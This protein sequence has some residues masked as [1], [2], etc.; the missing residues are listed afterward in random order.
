M[1]TQQQLNGLKKGDILRYNNNG[2]FTDWY[3]DY[4]RID[5]PFT[6]QKRVI[7]NNGRLPIEGEDP[8]VSKSLYSPI[9]SINSE[10]SDLIN[11]HQQ[12][13]NVGVRVSIETPDGRGSHRLSILVTDFT[14]WEL[15]DDGTQPVVDPSVANAKLRSAA[16]PDTLVETQNVE[17]PQPTLP[18]LIALSPLAD[19]EN[20]PYSNPVI[21]F[22]FDKEVKLGNG[23]ITILG[24]DKPIY[25]SVT[26][27][28]V[29]AS[30]NTVTVTP[31]SDFKPSV[32]YR[33]AIAANA[34]KD[35]A[36]NA[37]IDVLSGNT[38][39]FT[40]ESSPDVSI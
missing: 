3:V 35:V 36:T 8:N 4:P 33:I 31:R 22:T 9:V 32:K 30:G 18:M 11:Q 5:I 12:V 7:V 6:K 1:L 39:S 40:T 29:E 24:E 20:V 17:T 15:K 27:S 14:N 34:I 10:Q 21:E 13:S 25:C 19:A 23:N 38:Y 16:N 28:M 2:N 37:S 26:S